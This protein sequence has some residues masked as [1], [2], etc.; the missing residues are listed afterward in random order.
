MCYYSPM[1]NVKSEIEKRLTKATA[2]DIA[3]QI[4]VSKQFLSLVRHGKRLPSK[5]ILDWL[6]LERVVSYRRKR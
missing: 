3:Q 2:T 6:G 1:D 4:G 5:P